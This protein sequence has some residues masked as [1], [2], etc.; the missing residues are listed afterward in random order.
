MESTKLSDWKRHYTT[1]TEGR[2]KELEHFKPALR[3]LT[4]L[5]AET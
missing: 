4:D 3:P 5:H 2:A 1:L